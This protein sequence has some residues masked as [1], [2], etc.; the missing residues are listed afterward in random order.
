MGGIEQ[1]YDDNF[2]KYKKLYGEKEN[3]LNVHYRRIDLLDKVAIEKKY[4]N[5][6]NDRPLRFFMKQVICTDV[7]KKFFDNIKENGCDTIKIKYENQ[8][9]NLKKKF[10]IYDE[11]IKKNTKVFDKDEK[12]LIIETK[13]DVKIYGTDE[14][15]VDV[16][17]HLENFT[18]ETFINVEGF[19]R[20]NLIDLRNDLSDKDVNLM[21]DDD[22]YEAEIV[23]APTPLKGY[24][25]YKKDQL[26]KF[27]FKSFASANRHHA[28]LKKFRKEKV[29]DVEPNFI[30]PMSQ[31]IYHYN[32]GKVDGIRHKIYTGS[33]IDLEKW[34]TID[35]E[36]RQSTVYI[37]LISEYKN[38]K[39]VDE[40][41][42]IKN[43]PYMIGLSY[44]IEN[45][46]IETNN[47]AIN[48]GGNCIACISLCFARVESSTKESEKNIVLT[49][50]DAKYDKTAFENV[51]CDVV[52]YGG[53]EGIGKTVNT[54]DKRTDSFIQN[55]ME[56]YCTVDKEIEQEGSND[57][58]VETE[59]Q[60]MRLMKQKKNY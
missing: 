31:F 45:T 51:P 28:K 25:K 37:E 13:T 46:N 42:Q 26:L 9:S 40:K 10:D 23:Y 60:K 50:G 14:F 34:T 43:K 33:W 1:F 3:E 48:I 19:K 15:G 11:F 57:D 56:E 55:L 5:Y 7:P 27:K 49:L 39:H 41:W 20:K 8:N 59:E 38:I 52:S 32:A 47:M 58:E 18:P 4:D 35:D 30:S 21:P 44:D 6:K 16:L 24:N 2:Y 22:D 54:F 36:N 53:L 12:K 29:D 17:V